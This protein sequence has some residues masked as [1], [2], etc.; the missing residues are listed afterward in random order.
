MVQYIIEVYYSGGVDVMLL[1]EI[2]KMFIEDTRLD[3]DFLLIARVGLCFALA[4][5]FNG[6]NY[7]SQEIRDA[8]NKYNVFEFNKGGYSDELFHDRV[9]GSRFVGMIASSLCEEGEGYL[10]EVFAQVCF[11]SGM[12]NPYYENGFINFIRG[13]IDEHELEWL[14]SVD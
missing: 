8:Y 9:M 1:K 7:K 5:R 2:V 11:E 13:W 4:E 12:G 10:N 6:L 3:G 14:N